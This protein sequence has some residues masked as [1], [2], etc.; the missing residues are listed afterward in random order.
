VFVG[1]AVV[2]LVWVALLN[3]SFPAVQARGMSRGE[4]GET[5]WGQQAE[6]EYER[7][8]GHKF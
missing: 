4:A 3:S 1:L 2:I 8:Y 5:D 6:D 7:K